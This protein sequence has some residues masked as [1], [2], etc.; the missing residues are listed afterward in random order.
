M[1]ANKQVFDSIG[2]LISTI[3]FQNA[4][5]SFYEANSSKFEDKEE[6]KLEYTTI[7][8]NFL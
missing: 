8:C 5:V 4:Q 2:Q 6:N 7:Y 1:E 3:E